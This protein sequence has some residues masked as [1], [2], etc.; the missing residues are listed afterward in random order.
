MDAQFFAISLVILLLSIILHEVAHG[1]AALYFGDHTAEH[2]GRLTLNPL[3]HID[4][5]GSILMPALMFVPAALGLGNPGFFIAWAKPVPVNPLHYNN[6]RLGEFVVSSAGIVTNIAIAV[7]AAVLFHTTGRYGF[8]VWQNILTFAAQIN[9]VLAAFN[10]LPIPPL[11]G[12]KILGSLLPA[13][14]EYEYRKLERFGFLI[15]ILLLWSP[16]GS[17]VWLWI[18]FIVRIFRSVLAI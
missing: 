17:L 16:L 11:D 13:H 4:P 12:S 10:L 18:S 5:I 2:A 1:L 8:P 6:I 9:L 15:L 7:V 3:P 14:L